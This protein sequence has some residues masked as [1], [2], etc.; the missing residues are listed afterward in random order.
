MAALLLAAAGSAFAHGQ[1]GLAVGTDGHNARVAETLSTRPEAR[2]GS[3]VK[4][5]QAGDIARQRA[6]AP[7][8]RGMP[9][10]MASSTRSGVNGM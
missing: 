7:I 2:G 8:R 1:P 9:Q 3:A 6:P 10:A 4:M 5:A